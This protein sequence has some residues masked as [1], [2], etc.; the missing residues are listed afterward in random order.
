MNVR[1][2][3]IKVAAPDGRGH[4]RC[5]IVKSIVIFAFVLQIVPII[6]C[7]SASCSAASSRA[8]GPNRVGPKGLL[9]PLADVLQAA[10][11]GAVPPRHGGA[12]DDGD[13]AGDLDRHRG[14]D[15]RDHPV[16]P[17]RRL[18][19]RVRPLRH[20]RPDRRCST[21]S[22]SAR[23][24]FYGLVLGGWASGSKYSFLGAM[25]AAAQLISYEVALGLSLLGVAMTAG[26]LS[27][28][29]IVEAQGEHLVHRPAVRRLPDLPGRR[30]RGDL[31]RAVRPARGRRRARRRLQHRVRRDALRLVLHGRVHRGRDHLRHRAPPASSAAGTAPGPIALGAALDAPQ[32]VR[33][34]CSCSS[35]CGRRCR[36][37]ATTS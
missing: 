32:D 21:S 30:L 25:R 6:L 8:I 7:S 1:G 16:R 4:A 10:L 2:G 27:I 18:G 29:D 23:S 37:C 35:G 36:A 12:V 11:Q 22:R 3:P 28:V 34:S 20:R 17:V 24:R 5:M 9:Q 14:R 33:S 26:S 15:A 19:R 31:A 13:R